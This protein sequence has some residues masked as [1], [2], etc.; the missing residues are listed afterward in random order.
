MRSHKLMLLGVLSALYIQSSHA[1]IVRYGGLT[2]GP[3]DYSVVKEVCEHN[4]SNREIRKLEKAAERGDTSAQL[5]LGIL[6]DIKSMQKYQQL[7]DQR[8]EGNSVHYKDKILTF[9]LTKHRSSPCIHINN[10]AKE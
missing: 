2:Y 5:K 6:Y 1:E 7:I 10:T 8:I 3:I 9:V 4:Y